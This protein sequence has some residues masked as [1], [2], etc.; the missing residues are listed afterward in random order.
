MKSR[1][2]RISTTTS[3][4]DTVPLRIGG[5]IIFTAHGSQKLFGWFGGYGLE[6]TAG[7]MDSIG[8]S[9]GI[10]MATLAGSAEFFGGLLLIIG[11]LVRPAALLLAI[12]MLVA[13]F[14]VHSG[15]GLFL[16]NNG[17]EFGLALLAISLA[18]VVRGAGSVSVDRFIR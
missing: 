18:L 11:L 4:L 10:F 1:L 16:T 17:S 12:T 9:P 6:G 14:A 13:I 15:N 3:G 5:G 2:S 8:L 7:W